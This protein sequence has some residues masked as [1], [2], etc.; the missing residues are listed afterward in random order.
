MG[1][2]NLS[3]LSLGISILPLTL[4]IIRHLK[5]GMTTPWLQIIL[6]V[7]GLLILGGFVFA[8]FLVKNP[9][10][11]NVQTKIAL[12][13]DLLYICFFVFFAYLTI[14]KRF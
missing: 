1:S 4:F 12:G 10:T 9:K 13:L 11:R 5:I 3:N 7:Y 14:A 2:R 6:V 8:V